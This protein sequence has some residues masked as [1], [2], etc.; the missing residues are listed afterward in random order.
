MKKWRRISIFT[1]ESIERMFCMSN[2]V[3]FEILFMFRNMYEK[4]PSIVDI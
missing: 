3:P 1:R 4:S 2:K